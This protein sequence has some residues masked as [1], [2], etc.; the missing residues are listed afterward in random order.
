MKLLILGFFAL[1]GVGALQVASAAPNVIP[2]EALKALRSPKTAIFYSLEPWERLKKGDKTLHGYKILGKTTLA[3]KEEQGVAGAF[4][5]AVGD[6]DGRIAMC[7]DPRHALRISSETHIYEF[8][9][10][11]NCHQL[12]IYKDDKELASI[13]AAGSPKFLNSLLAAAQVP[14]SQTD[15][16]EQR[17]AER[18]K[19]ELAE[20]R[21]RAAMPK[22]VQSFWTDE[23]VPNV[24]PMREAL[25]HEYPDTTQRI[26]KLLEW[27]GNGAGPWSGYPSYEGAPEEL[28]RDYPTKTILAAIQSA[29]LNAMQIEGAA[30]FFAGWYFSKD[31]PGDLDLLPRPFKDELLKHSIKT[32]DSDKKQRSENAFR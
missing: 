21:W 9:L 1:A 18:K 26:L 7:F 27:Y 19:G 32:K 28:L 5:K 4:E 25:A 12:Y 29:K 11:Y 6:W 22:S 2:D 10:C 15:T 30:R 20:A 23:P 14:V 13:G 8:L 3:P 16:E 17:E 31:R 24:S